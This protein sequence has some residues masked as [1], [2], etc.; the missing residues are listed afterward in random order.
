MFSECYSLLSLPDISGWNTAHIKN[1]N[2]LF[3]GCYS[4]ISLPDI[5]K[6]NISKVNDKT[7]LSEIFYE[8]I[9]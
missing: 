3:F 1:I 5:S 2:N 8:K 7:D 9:L 6:W 4:L